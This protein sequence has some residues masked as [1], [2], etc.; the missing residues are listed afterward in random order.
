MN[1]EEAQNLLAALVFDELDEPTRTELSAYLETDA[2]LRRELDE[3]TRAVGLL[4][5]GAQRE[6]AAAQPVL[7]ARRLARLRDLPEPGD[8]RHREIGSVLWSFRTARIAAVAACMVI[9]LFLVVALFD[10]S[11]RRATVHDPGTDVASGGRGD[12]VAVDRLPEPPSPHGLKQDA[13]AASPGYEVTSEELALKSPGPSPYAATGHGLVGT[14]GQRDSSDSYFSLD[15]ASRP[16][17]RSVADSGPSDM[18]DHALG[19]G[20]L[21]WSH[22]TPSGRGGVIGKQS[23]PDALVLPT[24]AAQMP[25]SLN[26]GPPMSP[27]RPAA[28]QPPKLTPDP[29]TAIGVSPT[30][31]MELDATQPDILDSIASDAATGLRL[32]ARDTASRS[33]VGPRKAGPAR[34][35][36]P[37]PTSGL[38]RKAA[39]AAAAERAIQ[40]RR[41]FMPETGQTARPLTYEDERDRAA[42]RIEAMREQVRQTPIAIGGAIE[43]DKAGQRLGDLDLALEEAGRELRE[44]ERKRRARETSTVERDGDAPADLLTYPPDWPELTARDPELTARDDGESDAP[45]ISTPGEPRTAPGPDG[46]PAYVTD[47]ESNLAR[48]A[49]QGSAGVDGHDRPTEAAEQVRGGIEDLPTASTFRSFPVNPWTLT[50]SDRLSTFGIDTDDAS[51]ALC[52]RYIRAGYRPPPGAVRMEEFVNA[53]DYNYDRQSERT[54]T[55]HA[56]AAPAPFAPPGSDAVL[57][58]V[59][60]KG[61]VLGREGRKPAHLVFVIDAS[62]SMARAD[63]LGLVQ[64]GLARLTAQL[65]AGDRVSVVTFGSGAQ[66]VL[67][68][69][70]VDPDDADRITAAIAAIQPGTSTNLLEGLRRGYEL[71]GRHFRSG[72]INRVILCS[73]GVANIGQTDARSI[74]DR[75]AA[76]RAQGV[77]F[78]VAGFGMG[79]YNDKLL[80]QLA[81]EGDGN[82]LFIDSEQAAERAFVERLAA[83]LQTIAGDAK[84][85]VAFDPGRV[86]RYRLI[87]YENRDIADEKFRDD[88]VDAGEVGSGQSATALYELELV[89]PRRATVDLPPLGT[90]YVRYRD[91]DTGEVEEISRRLGNDIVRPMTAE[92]DPRFYLAAAA[93]HF[94]EHLRGSPHARHGNLPQLQRVMNKVAD[95]LPLD[96]RIAE[97][98]QLIA[99]VSD[100]PPAP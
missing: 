45:A 43:Q 37:R 30:D 44:L 95:A 32:I 47:L 42:K 23:G 29:E 53:F 48:P 6:A 90:V 82:Y 66:T 8:W 20:R 64:H 56:E 25:G 68:A 75:V 76:Y 2:S 77:T 70:A 1:R 15:E 9:G 60:V 51:Y 33:R 91:V 3:M 92:S 61:K 67:E 19:D 31:L 87:G 59:G 58:K 100:L 88:T 96:G 62:G 99:A 89:G 49:E 63:R 16:P 11:A 78:T 26:D 52:R 98:S 12:T 39:A 21:E 54:F 85:Q 40:T 22:R 28:L 86:R 81:N 4:Q 83:T 74:L 46:K 24:E 38:H 93:A 36:Q 35:S 94:A 10:P 50:A 79:G 41:E 17:G 5:A 84:I 73:D 13:P 55:I 72:Q 57:L 71:A 69:A 80:E 7:S 27:P 65:G 97:L 14:A 18:D 34:D